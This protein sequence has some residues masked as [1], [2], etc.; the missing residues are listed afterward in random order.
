MRENGPCFVNPDSNSTVLNK[1]SWNNDVNMLYI[2]QPVQ[3]GFSYDVLRNGTLNQLTQNW[4]MS[5]W[6]DGV[7][8]ANNTLGVGTFSSMDMTKT[9]NTTAKAGRALWHFLQIWLNEFPK[10]KPRNNRVSLWTESYGGHYG[11]EFFRFF[12]EQNKKLS[13]RPNKNGN[14]N[15]HGNGNENGHGTGKQHYQPI[16][17]DTLGI[18]NGCID[19][20]RQTIYFPQ[21]A[22]NNSYGIQ[23]YNRTI[24]DQ[25]IN[26]FKKP[27]GC[28][29]KIERCRRLASA[30]DP[31]MY[32]NNATVNKACI[33]ANDICRYV[34]EAAFYNYNTRSNN[35]IRNFFPD[36]FPPNYYIGY[37]NQHWVQAAL[38]VPLNYS[39]AV[40]SVYDS[41]QTTGDAARGSS[42]GYLADIGALLDS[43]I[44][45]TMLYGDR[46]YT[47]NWYGGEAVSLNIPY[48]RQHKSRRAGYAKLQTNESYVGGLVRQHG[49]FSFTRVYQSGHEVPAYQP[50]TAYQIFHR[51]MFNRDITTGRLS[52]VDN[53]EYSTDGLDYIWDVRDSIPNPQPPL[54]YILNMVNTCTEDQIQSVRNGSAVIKDFVLMDDNAKKWSEQWLVD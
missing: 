2:D 29:D 16:Y 10:Y 11:P 52:T 53:P 42:A 1:W 46:D 5:P 18:V 43:G 21:M 44:K 47:C 4:D 22:F 25:Q 7:P 3:V 40:R 34:I 32:G 49:N 26:T 50:E 36:P 28:K 23:I 41:F 13:K 33:E 31:N 9:A 30:G 15:C 12:Q 6:K 14:E 24:Y 51:S 39:F 38:G 8:K 37:L 27:G 48:P 45:V 19:M 17:L 20:L 35:D 54:C